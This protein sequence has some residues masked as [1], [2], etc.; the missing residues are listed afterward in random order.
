MLFVCLPALIGEQ[1]QVV[2]RGYKQ[3]TCFHEGYQLFIDLAMAVLGAIG[4]INT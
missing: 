2:A 1:Y 4:S 3:T